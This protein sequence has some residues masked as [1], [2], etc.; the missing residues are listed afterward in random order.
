M[1]CLALAAALAL[2]LPASA[3][4]DL[5]DGSG[6][7]VGIRS[8]SVGT[9]GS[10]DLA[11]DVSLGWRQANG[12]DYGVRVGV[13][14][15]RA[16]TGQNEAWVGPTVG[17]TQALGRGALGRVE[18]SALY[19]AYDYTAYDRVNVIGSDGTIEGGRTVARQSLAANVTATVARP[20]RLAGSVRLHPTLGGFVAADAPFR[21]EDSAYPDQSASTRA[22]A[23]VHIGLPVSFRLFGQGV[24]VS[25][26][27][28]VPLTGGGLLRGFTGP[29]A[30]SGLRLNF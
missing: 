19:Q 2:V 24:T 6:G 10:L 5:A 8:L 12:L 25:N 28:Q 18:G 23:G 1:R 11:G 30:G 13:D 7:Y 27:I 20:V 3:Q 14:R 15:G 9:I 22:S 26:A 21:F 17:Y 4:T 29:Y 16:T